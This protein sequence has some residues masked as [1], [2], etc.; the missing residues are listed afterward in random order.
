M[1][2]HTILLTMMA[3]GMYGQVFEVGVHGGVSRLSGR[4]IGTISTG[5]PGG[6]I[7]TTL[8]DGWRMGFRMTLN[9]WSFFA[10][11]FGYA[12]NRTQLR[13]ATTPPEESGMAIHQGLYNFLVYATPEGTKVRPFATGGVH[14]S[15]FVPPGASVTQGGGSNKFGVNYGGGIKVRVTE[16][17]GIRFDVREYL[18]GKPFDL[19]GASGKLRHME[20][21]AGFSFMM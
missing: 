3:A 20:V 1:I 10:H 11:E 17:W 14:F 4:N 8:E 9:N 15:N 16:M 7:Q 6:G 5:A 18:T 19:P 21:S 2:K 12:Y 13:F